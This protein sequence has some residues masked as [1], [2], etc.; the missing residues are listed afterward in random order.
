MKN[1]GLILWNAI[2]ICEEMSKTSW[3]MGFRLVQWL[4]IILFLRRASQGSTTLGK[5]MFYLVFMHCSRGE[6]LARRYLWLQTLR[7][8]EDMDASEIRPSKNQ[9]E[10]S[11]DNT[12]RK[13]NSCSQ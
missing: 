1:G 6:I 7:R 12:K 8:W 10:R 2:V 11:I 3:Q 5:K 4:N 13:T 9:R